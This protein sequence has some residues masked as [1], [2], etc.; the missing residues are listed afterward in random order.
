MR[1]L[2]CM[3][4]AGLVAALALLLTL[5]VS[6]ATAATRIVP[7][8]GVWDGLS[9]GDLIGDVWATAYSTPASAS[10]F[11]GHPLCMHLGRTGAILFPVTDS[12]ADACSIRQGAPVFIN[13][14]SSVYT[15]FED[16]AQRRRLD[17]RADH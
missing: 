17:G 2:R 7:P 5:C 4:C 9:A 10:P 12:P 8:A 1:H 14:L 11:F 3:S 15:S 16:R 13:G 6:S